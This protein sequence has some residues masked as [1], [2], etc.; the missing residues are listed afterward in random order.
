MKN[1]KPQQPD[2]ALILICDGGDSIRK[3]NKLLKAHGL[4][5]KQRRADGDQVYLKIGK[6]EK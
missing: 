6:I 3:I 5:V 1:A 4:V 2:E